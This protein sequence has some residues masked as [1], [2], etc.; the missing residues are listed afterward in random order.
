MNYEY[1]GWD[2]IYDHMTAFRVRGNY[3][4]GT[5]SLLRCNLDVMTKEIQGGY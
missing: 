4:F 2:E 1:V 3:C 5:E